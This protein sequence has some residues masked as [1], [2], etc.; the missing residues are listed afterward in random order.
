MRLGISNI[1][2]DVAEDN[3]IASLLNEY[4]IDSIDIA[5]GKYFAEP[6]AASKQEIL[7]VK[8]WWQVRGIEITGMQALLFGTVGLNVFGNKNSQ[9]MLL[10][11]LES[12]CRI[13]GTLG[14]RRLVFGSPKNRDRAGIDDKDASDIAIEFF[15][16]L[17]RIA[18]NYDVVICLEPNPVCYGA[19]FM[20]T[21]DETAEIV[22]GVAHHA[23]KMQF[24]T[25]A[26]TVN[27]ED[28][29]AILRSYLDLIGHIHLSDPQLLPI[30]DGTTDHSTIS[31]VLKQHMPDRLLTIE[32]LATTNEPHSISIKRALD[33]GIRLYRSIEGNA[34]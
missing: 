23:L 2:W 7:Q 12:V 14:A 11:H 24:D 15:H 28:A 16:V 30:G 6:K 26:V 4:Q 27:K 18:E 19:N 29:A 8:E 20:T 1:A 34:L 10:D 31:H 21:T 25:G 33:Y 3:E 17:A 22:K 13:A 9:K 5:P 32:M